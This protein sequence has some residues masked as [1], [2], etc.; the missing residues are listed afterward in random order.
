MKESK[1]RQKRFQS[2]GVKLDQERQREIDQA[3]KSRKQNNQ[4]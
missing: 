2:V 3:L 4:K 1:D